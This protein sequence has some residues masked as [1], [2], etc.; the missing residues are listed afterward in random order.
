MM[1]SFPTIELRRVTH[2]DLSVITDL[3]CAVFNAAPWND[4]WTVETVSVRLR[5]ML[6]TPGSEGIMA[7]EGARPVGCLLGYREQWFDGAQFY[8]KEMFVHPERQR[9]GIGASLMREL[10]EVVRRQGVARIYLLTERGGEAAD[11]YR[12][13]GFYPSQR[14]AMMSCQLEPVDPETA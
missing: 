14:M 13:Q 2:D 11:F 3:Y 4:A 7:L 10:K 9:R 8:L 12:A 5:D 1:M 6:A